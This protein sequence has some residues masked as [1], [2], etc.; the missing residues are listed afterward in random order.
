M[1]RPNP[2]PQKKG[3]QGPLTFYSFPGSHWIKL[4]TTNVIDKTYWPTTVILP[5]CDGR[6]SW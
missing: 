4:R 1:T 6:N 2:T 3:P 5:S